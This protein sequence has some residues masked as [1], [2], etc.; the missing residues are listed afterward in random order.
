MDHEDETPGSLSDIAMWHRLSGLPD[1]V[2]DDGEV[3]SAHA[4]QRAQIAKDQLR[5]EIARLR[6]VREPAEVALADGQ[7]WPVPAEAFACDLLSP[8]LRA[9]QLVYTFPTLHET[10]Q[11]AL[12]QSAELRRT[13]SALPAPAS[14][15]V[16]I[17]RGLQQRKQRMIQALGE[18]PS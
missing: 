5:A 8:V 9:G 1:N 18:S 14:Y 3:V 17:E 6:S 7:H 4:G 16:G 2:T 13:M 11:R 15:P 12:E 10:R